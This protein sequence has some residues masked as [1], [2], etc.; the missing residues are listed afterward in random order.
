M[1]NGAATL[2][3]TAAF[4]GEARFAQI[5]ERVTN[6][7]QRQHDLE[8][9]MRRGF[10]ELSQAVNVLS[11][12]LRGSSRTQWP[13]IWSAV[14][15]CFTVIT[16]IGALAYMP[17]L[18]NISRIDQN[19]TRFQSDVNDRLATV[20]TDGAFQSFKNTYENN[21]VVAT[22]DNK[23]RFTKLEVGLA[24]VVPRKEHER[25][26]G[27]EDQ[28]FQDL[29]RQV[30]ELKLSANSTYNA[31]DIILDLRNRLDRVESLMPSARVGT[32]Q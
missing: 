1:P 12:E 3:A 21:R 24:E 2:A 28:R 23:D 20:I 25:V 5:G 9:E 26:W 31:R 17:V 18:T 4:E 16:A 32:T 15:V 30:D 6:L 27:A 22:A 10:G 14:G 8:T 11:T 13:V 29:Q 7:S 19:L